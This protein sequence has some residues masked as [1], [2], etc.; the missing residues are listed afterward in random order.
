MNRS[1]C[2]GGGGRG[3]TVVQGVSMTMEDEV[4][5]LMMLKAERTDGSWNRRQAS[6]MCAQC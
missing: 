6:Y 2:G 1:G 3:D 4:K 5:K